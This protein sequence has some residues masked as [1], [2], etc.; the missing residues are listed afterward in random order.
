MASRFLLVSVMLVFGSMTALT[1]Q[2]PQKIKINQVFERI[3]AQISTGRQDIWLTGLQSGSTYRIILNAAHTEDSLRF[4]VE[5]SDPASE[6]LARLQSNMD[7]PQQRVFLA[8][9]TDVALRITTL[10]NKQVEAGT[11]AY[12]YMSV[13]CLSCPQDTGWVDRFVQQHTP[14]F[15]PNLSTTPGVSASSLVTNTL[16]GGNCFNV[17]GITSQ[18]ATNSRGTFTNG[19]TNIG[20]QSGVVLCT[21]NVNILP[22]PNASGS[23]SG[24]TA[25][26]GNNSPDDA[27]L[28]T[29]TGTNQFD[30][31]KI[32]FD[33]RPTAPQVTFD[34][35]F[36]SEE[37]C[38]FV[39]SN[40][41]DVFGFFISGPGI[42]GNQNIAL[43]PSTTTPVLIN[44]V[45]HATN[46][47]YYINNNNN[48]GACGGQGATNT[49][50]CALDGYTTVFTA[51]AN[52]IPCSTYHIKLALA[53][54]GDEDLASAVFLR[55]GSFNA[56]GAVNGSV[57]YPGSNLFVYENCGQVYIR[58]TR[59]SGD[60][61]VDLEVAFTIGGAS[62]ATP[63]D[64][65]APLSGPFIIPA[66]QT[67]IDVPI[68]VF[69]DAITEGNETIVILLSTPCSCT[70]TPVVVNIRDQIPVDVTLADQELCGGTSATLAPGISG[71]VAPLT[72][73]WSNNATSPSINIT[74][75]GTNTYTVT[76]TDACGST[77]VDEAIVTLLPQP[78]ATIS[79][80]GT[81]CAGA[82]G[83]F[84]LSVN[85]TGVGPW[86][87]GWQ[88]GG[89]GGTETFNTS[90]GTI[91]VT[92]SG[93]YT[94]T[95]VAAGPCPGTV[96]GSA[97]ISI[98]NVAMNLTPTN[99]TCFGG[100]GNITSSVSG[101]TAP[102]TYL[103][104]QASTTPNLTGVPIGTYEVTVTSTAS[105][106]TQ[107]ASATLT[108]PPLLSATLNASPIDCTTPTTPT[109][110]QVNGGTPN[111]TYAW[112]GGLSGPSPNITAG[113]T[114]TVTITDNQSCTTT[115]SVTV[116]ASFTP[117]T[118]VATAPGQI[119]CINSEISINGTGSST[120]SN[121]TYDWNGPGIVSGENTL[122]PVVDAPG[123]YVLT[124]TNTDNGCTR[125]ASVTIVQ[126]VTLPNA[127]IANPPN[128]G[129]TNPSFAL[130]GNGSTTGAGINFVWSTTDGNFTGGTNTLSPTINQ[131]GTYTLVVTNTNNGCTDDAN[132]TVTGNTIL[133]TAIIDPATTI[134]CNDPTIQL[135]A[136]GSSSGNG[137]NLNYAWSG[138][139][140]GINSGGNSSSPTVDVGGTYIVTVTDPSNNC[141]ATS[142]ISVV[143][144]NTLPTAVAISGGVISCQ[145]PSINLNGT[146]STV[147]PNIT[148]QWGTNNGN[149]VSG[150]NTLTPEINQG[151]TYTI[152]VT[153]NDNGCTRTASVTV[154]AN[155]AVP[156]A[157][158][159]PPRTR[160]CIT[161]TLSIAGS[162]STGPNFTYQWTASPGNIVSGANTLNPTIN[163]AGCYTLVVTN[164][165]NNCTSEDQVCIED[166][167]DTPEAVLA[168]PLVIDCNNPTIEIDGTASTQPP[169]INY[170]WAG[171]AGGINSGG[172]SD[173]PT[174]DQPGTYTV[175]ITNS[176]S[177]CTDVASVVVVRDIAPPNAQAGPNAILSCTVNSLSLNGA[178]SSV[179]PIFTYEWG[180]SNGNI[181]AGDNTLN[182]LIDDAG[183]YTITVTN[184]TNGCTSTDV[185]VI[186]ADQNSPNAG[187]GPNRTLNCNNPTVMLAA[188]VSPSGMTYVWQT[189]DGNIVSGAN[190]LSPTVNQEG[191]YTIVVTNPVNGCTDTDEVEVIN[192]ISFPTAVIAPPLQLDCNNPTIELDAGDSDPGFNGASLTYQWTGPAGGINFG[193]NTSSPTIDQPGTYSLIIR[194]ISSQCTASATVQ[195]TSDFAAPTAIATPLGILTCQFPEVEVSGAGSSSGYPFEYQWD[196]QNGNILSGDNTLDLIVGQI[197]T[198]VLTVTNSENG[199]T[200]SASATVTT[201]QT[202]PT[203]TAG[204]PQILTCNNPAV[205]LSGTG[206]S[207]GIQFAYVWATQNGNIVSGGN[208]LNPLVNAAGTYELSVINTL[209]GCVSNATVN[210]SANQTSP[211][212]L[213][214]PGGTL[215]CTVPALNLNGSGSSVGSNFNVQWSTSNG[216]ITAGTNSLTPTINA[217]GTYT[218]VV[219]NTQTGCTSSATTS[220][221]ADASVPIANAGTPSTITC[222]N[223]TVNLSANA[224]TQGAGITYTW[225]GPGLTNSPTALNT[226]AN[227]PGT[228][229]LLVT[230]TINGCSAVASVIVD[231]DVVA[232]QVIA[233]PRDTVNCYFPILT[234]GAVADSTIVN[235]VYQWTT[236]N[237]NIV[238]GA[239]SLQPQVDAGGLYQ[240]LITNPSN[241]CTAT[242]SV[243]VEMDLANPSVSGGLPG[244]I[245]CQNPVITL[246][247]TASTPNNAPS[248]VWTSATG[249]IASGAN[250]LQPV[251]DAPGTYQIMVTDLINGCTAT[252][253]VPVTKDA[254]V[255]TA[256]IATTP[257]LDCVTPQLV[258][259]ATASTQGLQY[260]W[261]T[262][263]GQW[264]G[265][266]NGLTLTVIQA[267]TYTLQVRN[268]ANN[269]L[270]L[271]TIQIAIDTVSPIVNAGPPA[272]ISCLQPVLTLSGSTNVT[273]ADAQISWTTQNGQFVS[274]N[275]TLSP[276]VNASGFYTV[277]V[278]DQSNGCTATSTVQILLDQNTPEADAGTE[279]LL[280]CDVSSLALDGSGSSQGS[281]F[282]YSWSGPAIVSGATTLNPIIDAPGT[283]NLLVSNPNN[284]CTSVAQVL[285]TEDLTPPVIS[286]APPIQLNCA[287]LLDTLAATSILT[288]GGTASY[289]WSTTNGQI[290]SGATTAEPVVDAPGNY[291]VLVTN[292]VTGCTTT[293]QITVLEDIV[294]PV[295]D[296]GPTA[297]LNC[298][299]LTQNINATATNTGTN[300][301]I[302]WTSGASGN[303]VSGGSTLAP[304]VNAPGAYTL[305]V[306][307]TDNFC[308]ATDQVIITQS[309][310]NP[311]AAIVAPGT[312]TCSNQSL[313]LSGAGSSTGQNFA[314]QWSGPGITSGGTTLNPTVTAPGTY[315]LQV[316]NQQN[317]CVSLA[318]V[319][320]PQ[321]ITAPTAVGGPTNTLNCAS[322][323]LQLNGAGS[324][325]GANFNYL[326]TVSAGSTGNIVSGST[327]LTPTVNQP[328]MYNLLVTNNLN[329]CTSTSSATVNQDTNAPLAV[330]TT[331]GEL[332]CAITSLNLSGVGSSAGSNFNAQ[333]T[334]Q[335]GTI[336][337]GQTTLA[338]TVTAP[339]TYT[340]QI[341][342]YTNQCTTLASVE[343]TNDVVP[344]VVQAGA[345][346]RLTCSITSLALSATAS[347]N[348]QGVS[349][350]WAGP[351]VVSG[352]NSLTPTINQTGSYTITATDLY[353]GCTSTDIVVITPDIT[354]PTVAIA[355]PNLLTC[356]INQVNLNA[357]ASSQGAEFVYSWSG[358]GIVGGGTTLA[359]LVNQPG[360]YTLTIRDTDNGCVEMQTVTVPQDIA[361]PIADANEGFE[362]TCS[363][364]SGEL[365]AAG[366][367]SGTNF[368]YLWSTTNGNIVS[369]QSGSTPEVDE[370]GQYLLLVTNTATGCTQTAS[371]SVIENTNYPEGIELDTDLPKCGGQGGSI[372]FS[373]VDG[374]VGPYLYSI[375]DGDNFLTI[376]DFN[377]LSPGDYDLVIQDANGCEYEESFTFPVPV[378]PAVTTNPNLSLEFGESATLTAV[379][380]I[381]YY[382]VDSIIWSPMESITLTNDPTVVIARPFRTTEYT[383]RIVNID[384]CEAE[385]LVLIKVGEPAIYVPNVIAAGGSDND[386]FWIFAKDGSVKK[387]T[388]LQ[389][390]DRWGNQVFQADEALPNDASK[391]WDGSFRNADM[392]PAVFV[393]WAEIELE[394]GE[395]ILLEGDV[396]V[397]R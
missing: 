257:P 276:Q 87:V 299:L 219:T 279:Q 336:T 272:V 263:N 220:V 284:G 304:V 15:L 377:D 367:S 63:G 344:P 212:A 187:A 92:N 94:L 351:G 331:P 366:S 274:G 324:S 327:T 364:M 160:N 5:M 73:Q 60:I 288:S 196:T 250:T 157:N 149:I 97:T 174:V 105:G 201:N 26:F 66:G 388:T 153:N 182:P 109:D 255:P 354:Q 53:D 267:G 181:V 154:P 223:P 103:W 216:N 343:V 20:I 303:I 144:N 312:L 373:T 142:S 120:G 302:N 305:V 292:S 90:P 4:V 243:D 57:V 332:T 283:Y 323:S 396:T 353:N 225:S 286:T 186:T 177:G 293:A 355:A 106:C 339:G 237:G 62:T 210:V 152:T 83:T 213:V 166:N 262:T 318:T 148:Y 264:T 25:G 133:P 209:T 376:N 47:A 325:L 65:Y 161:P 95:S 236:T 9:S 35:V 123:N 11:P 200:R 278:T 110:L 126:N 194:N 122:T 387:I 380:N 96:S 235:P 361:L 379:L 345:D 198:Y 270:A 44:N 340:L 24:N 397:V 319:Q 162:G 391:G 335:N 99:P 309:V 43:I 176:S 229:N 375:D 211:I 46:N 131:A 6:S 155:N 113:G 86:T 330:A 390:H 33:F 104:S 306:T 347:G 261:T 273:P 203:A 7:R 227:V 266:S 55:G 102:Y 171:P 360:A 184:T 75:P 56:G 252:A 241:G 218:L 91:Q 93:T 158:A 287:V 244:F 239:A 188:N 179:G 231:E 382:Q 39:G 125:T 163:Q 394:S 23:T 172:N 298:T 22:G 369:G 135:D 256:D 8:D 205:N 17:T 31:T 70:Q 1:A 147:G 159:G 143:A 294:A 265:P 79:G 349:V 119:N 197:G 45:N 140:G 206:S 248:I 178:G 36:G 245:D 34:F 204:P 352:G 88:G 333:W 137:G 372:L 392:T 275:T 207:A 52:V 259:D 127:V 28:A 341:T 69:G 199:C 271:N 183:T 296:A 138:P 393:W 247:A 301:T 2:N 277:Q 180:T 289:A 130:N 168:P 173:S 291:S 118:A 165:T 310:N 234:L 89:G 189:S 320:V 193:G 37:Y 297:Q 295:V 368:S 348:P 329:G 117:P 111:Y 314:Y 317:N 80:S 12:V 50:E 328:G 315:T 32:E 59:G 240:L 38:E 269:C 139:A 322:S 58:F 121:F 337:A 268:P 82:S 217:V 356:A 208:T 316:T 84:N 224:S 246:T 195:V 383:V 81:V 249:N 338:P 107:T 51:T 308:S 141:T 40:F 136:S 10:T 381:P 334:T 191:T 3:P 78:T 258:L 365:S 175:T 19:A 48:T 151:G 29:L 230:N 30:V 378:E 72:Y 214:A 170:T 282:Q 100:N 389:I 363:V 251:V 169:G 98:V 167:F 228:Y 395:H 115:A 260:S 253:S 164:T 285:V 215:S 307:N 358:P 101:G 192:N 21:G 238:S 222:A 67:F 300:F 359:P 150:D 61:N 156:I 313:Q 49:A 145:T 185:V 385:A 384:G 346:D 233:T 134:T 386:R 362:L 146:G 14:D 254:N 68:T 27:D 232:P 76:V 190:T 64:D 202:F 108:E 129:C 112:T 54:I 74:T 85:M 242:Q 342:N 41:N 357:N 281:L 124:V 116:A 290:V 128:I 226:T 371:V 132:V 71:G 18:G 326:W 311:N 114:Y 370:P 13:K 42:T 350:A 77:T 16:I 374:G 221:I 321:N 280:T